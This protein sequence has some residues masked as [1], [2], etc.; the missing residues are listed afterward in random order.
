MPTVKP[1]RFVLSLLVFL[2]LGNSIQCVTQFDP[3]LT[4][5]ITK[6]VVDG[7]ITDQPPPYQIRV[8]YSAPY[9]NDVTIFGR[10]PAQAKISIRDDQGGIE[11]L[12][13]TSNGNFCLSWR[14]SKN[15]FIVGVGRTVG[16]SNHIRWWLISYQSINNQFSY[17]FI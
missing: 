3:E 8:T 12:R 14:A 10:S 16:N 11:E 1:L 17:V 2:A 13:Y 9:T 7:L 6:L 5:D 4:K 15:S